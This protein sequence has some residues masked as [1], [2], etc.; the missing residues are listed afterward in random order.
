MADSGSVSDRWTGAGDAGMRRRLHRI[1]ALSLPVA[2]AQLSQSLFS[3]VDTAMVGALGPVSLAA[4]GLAGFANFVAVAAVTGLSTGVQTLAARR[5]GAGGRASTYPVLAGGLALALI[6]SIPLSIVLFAATPALFPLLNS[7]PA[8]VAEGGPYLQARL[9]GLAAVAVAMVFRGWWNGV[10]RPMDYLRCLVLMHAINVI[11]SYGLI[12]GSLGLPEMGSLGAGLGTTVALYV[13]AAYYLLLIRRSRRADGARLTLPGRAALQTMLRLSIPSS[14]QLVFFALGFE[15]LL[16]IVGT[17]GTTELAAANVLTV[18]TL[19]GMRIGLS[20]GL[21]S[22]SLVGH[23]M[24]RGD[25][26]GARQWGRDAVMVGALAM[27]VLGTPLMLTPDLVL[28]L[29]LHDP[30]TIE[31]AR[32]PMMLVGLGFIFDAVGIVL[33]NTLLGA[34]ASKQ[35]MSVTTALQWLLCLPLAWLVARHSGY[36]LLGI[37]VCFTGY[38]LFQAVILAALWEAARWQTIRV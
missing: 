14:V 38:R 30:A 29:F 20:L 33:I 18:V 6:A 4:V 10:Q 32:R 1:L 16:W 13:G 3:V 36:G 19:I 17:I 9:A 12:F 35:V 21:A 24:G 11:L 34:G 26:R 15:L 37:W 8:V 23:A 31:L 28:A 2:G 25:F 27:A 5:L 22:A 7:D